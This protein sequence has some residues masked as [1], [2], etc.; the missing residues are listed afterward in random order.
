MSEAPPAML[1]TFSQ[2]RKHGKDISQRYVGGDEHVQRLAGVE[3]E[4]LPVAPRSPDI[5]MVW[6]VTAEEPAVAGPDIYVNTNAC[7]SDLRP[8]L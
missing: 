8:V 4:V 5:F 6:R 7:P 2:L 3:A 1:I